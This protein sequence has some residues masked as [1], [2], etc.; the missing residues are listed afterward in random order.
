MHNVLA[1][2]ARL[3]GSRLAPHRP[4]SPD[5]VDGLDMLH[6]GS[7][8]SRAQRLISR[9]HEQ[10]VAEAR[11]APSF[12]PPWAAL[13]PALP[14]TRRSD[15]IRADAEARRRRL[16]ANRNPVHDAEPLQFRHRFR[17]PSMH[18]MF[19]N[20]TGRLRRRALG[21]YMVGFFLHY[22]NLRPTLSQRDE[23]FDASYETLLSL[24][25]MIGEAKPRA[26]PDHVIAGLENATY[27][28]WATSES[29]QRCP[30]CLDDVSFVFFS[31]VI[32][33]QLAPV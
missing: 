19:G 30:I 6:E 27:K 15:P 9:F 17:D 32:Y 29:D 22:C 20:H 14:P 5:D 23:D 24:G 12:S 11:E 10:A 1:R 31:R 26:T 3:A 4:S 28:E 33:S 21:D 8:T 13:P 7:S 16:A 18:A 2:Q 25:G